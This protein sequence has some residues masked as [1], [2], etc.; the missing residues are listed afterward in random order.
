M[1]SSLRVAKL[2]EDTVR[3]EATLRLPAARC[4]LCTDNH[5][6]AIVKV[7]SV[8]KLACLI[9]A[10]VVIVCPIISRLLKVFAADGDEVEGADLEDEQN[11]SL[12]Q[13]F[14]FIKRYI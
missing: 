3:C 8:S 14:S 10:C 4:R 1:F 11:K 9:S 2:K 7:E 5:E 13:W 6:K 12:S